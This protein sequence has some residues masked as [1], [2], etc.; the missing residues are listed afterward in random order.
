MTA[1]APSE[2]EIV[3]TLFSRWL[4]ALIFLVPLD[5]A[6]GYSNLYVVGDSLTD[7]GNNAIALAPNVT[8]LPI[9]GNDFIPTFPYASGRYTN[10]EVWAQTLASALGL[11]A[12]P[13]LLGG[14]D[15]AFGGAQTGPLTPNP[16]PGGLFAPFPPSLETQ[17]AFFL[18]QHGNIAPATALYI[19]AGGGE[20]VLQAL[21]SINGCGGSLGCVDTVIQATAEAF[22]GNIENI[23]SALQNAGATNI[24]LW[25]VPDVGDAPVAHA[26]GVSPLATAIASSM[27][28]ALSSAIGTD[29]SIKLFDAFGLLDEVVAD[30]NMF[31]LVNVTDACAQFIACD[32]S[33]YLFWDG[34]HPTSAADPIITDA[35]LSLIAE[36]PEP[37][38]VAVL[39]VALVVLVFARRR[40]PAVE[41]KVRDRSVRGGRPDGV[42]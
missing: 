29:P 9:P 30:P 17:A 42:R 41:A 37:S 34:I 39:S 26:L 23:I 22:A 18:A 10:D 2:G 5:A 20:D 21:R 15:Y 19:V 14:T 25:D 1:R 31:G 4:S 11:A 6:A 3:K 24:V 33:Q 16:L 40:P 36:V 12:A 28:L 8:P 35:I 32:P 38:T 27:N 13:S 7:S